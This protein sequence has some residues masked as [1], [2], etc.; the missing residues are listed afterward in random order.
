MKNL[1]AHFYMAV[2]SETKSP[3]NKGVLLILYRKN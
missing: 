3:M 1:F 2:F